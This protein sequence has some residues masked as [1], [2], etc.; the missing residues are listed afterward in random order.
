MKKINLRIWALLDRLHELIVGN[1][2]VWIFTASWFDI[3]NYSVTCMY[4]YQIKI[5][6][7]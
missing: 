3:W 4:T 7:I 6:E 5:K 1:S 2:A